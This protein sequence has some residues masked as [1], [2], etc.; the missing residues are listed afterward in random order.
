MT[1]CFSITASTNWCF[2]YIFIYSGLRSTFT[3]LK[4]GTFM[5]C[6]VPRTRKPTRPNVLLIHGFGANPTWQWLS[7]V[8]SLAPHFNIYVPELVF[9]GDSFTTRPERTEAFQAECVKQ[10]MEMNSVDRVMVVGLSYGGFVAYSMASQ[11]KELVERV[12]IC[13]SGVALEDK[14]LR[15]GLF[16][17]REVEEAANMLVPR[18]KEKLKELFGYT[19]VKPPKVLP[20][21]FLDDFIYEMSA[22]YAEEK[23]DLLRSIANGRKLSELPK[24][25][26]PTLIIWGDQDKIFP[27]QLAYRLKSHL[28]EIAQVTTI[29]ETGHACIYEKSKEFHKHLK[30]FLLK[31]INDT[32]VQTSTLPHH[33]VEENGNQGQVT[34]VT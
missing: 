2:K 26:Q 19:F 33:R 10:V 30:S 9:F 3:D 14:D 5:H 28:G 15:E 6:W 16:P 13:C 1:K 18:S 21:C 7:T 4:D 20:S 34:L 29:K 12:V 22:Q 32:K 27:L 24:I 8:R 11:F 17:V 23:R 25:S 31:P